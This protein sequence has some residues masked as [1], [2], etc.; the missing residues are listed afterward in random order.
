MPL[1]QT[2]MSLQLKRHALRRSSVSGELFV[3]MRE[4]LGAPAVE[5]H[6]TLY[7]AVS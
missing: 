4:W 6:S 1:V 5:L 7:R 3:V 2:R